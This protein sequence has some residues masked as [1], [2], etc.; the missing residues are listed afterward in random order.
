MFLMWSHIWV[1]FH[2]YWFCFLHFVSA[3]VLQTL[4]QL[5]AS[6][7]VAKNGPV[8]VFEPV[9]RVCKTTS[10]GFCCQASMWCLWLFCCIYGGYRVIHVSL[11]ESPGVSTS[12]ALFRVSARTQRSWSGRWL[13]EYLGLSLLVLQV[14]LYYFVVALEQRH[15]SFCSC[16]W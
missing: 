2:H 6:I 9:T 11:Q 10:R 16:G 7:L 4:N 3:V 8:F 14:I 12:A 13:N 15:L 5:N 1:D